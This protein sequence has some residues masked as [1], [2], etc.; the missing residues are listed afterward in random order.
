M[1][2]T[3]QFRGRVVLLVGA[4]T[5]MGRASAETFASVGATVVMGDVN[6][7]VDTAWEEI[8]AAH[9]GTQ[10]FA[11]RIDVTDLDSCRAAVERTVSEHGR[12]DVL[13]NFAGVIQEAHDVESMPVEE[14]DRVLGINL[15][16]HFLMAKAAV[17]QFKA[18]KAG[19]IIL[20]TSIWSHEGFD[21]FA[22]YC[23]SKGGLKLFTQ[24]LAKEMLPYG[25]NVNAIAPG[26]INTE[27]HQKAL[28]D[29]ATA[30]GWSYDDVREK[31]WGKIPTGQAGSPQ[32]VAN[33]VMYLASD[34]ASY[35]V[36]ATLDINGAILIR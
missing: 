7:A 24:S 6:P 21:L 9:P 10:G 12:I 27:L 32:D 34:E 26:I 4:A 36:A 18:Q 1:V 19:R 20:I 11:T 28:R 30:R 13:A 29:E 2:G 25:V 31:E 8:Q 35:V 17:G 14:W 23:A 15:R 22:A 5:G 3:E 16:G 33:G